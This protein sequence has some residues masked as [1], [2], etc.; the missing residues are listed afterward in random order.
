MPPGGGG[1]PQMDPAAMMQMVMQSMPP[2]AMQ[3]VAG[4]PPAGNGEVESEKVDKIKL[5]EDKISGLDAQM[6]TM[7]S[8]MDQL[9]QVLGVGQIKQGQLSLIDA[10]AKLRR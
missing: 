2:E 6:G 7:N 5:L 8:K 10:I 3:A 9:L 1:A 4:A